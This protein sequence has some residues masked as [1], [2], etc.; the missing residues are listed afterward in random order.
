MNGSLKADLA[1]RW[2]TGDLQIEGVIPREPSLEPLQ[3]RNQNRPDPTEDVE[4]TNHLAAVN[5]TKQASSKTAKRN[6]A[7]II[8]DDGDDAASASNGSGQSSSYKRR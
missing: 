1:N 6:F 7:V 5:E 2:L 4:E 3:E 8:D